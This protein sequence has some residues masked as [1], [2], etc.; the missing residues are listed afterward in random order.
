LSRL[1]ISGTKIFRQCFEDHAALLAATEAACAAPLDALAARCADALQNGGKLL[2]FGN[3][4]SA[5]DAQHLAA[6]LSIRFVADRR[7]LAAIALTTD[8]SALTACANDY[9]FDH[10]FSRQ[11]EALG[12]AGD[13]AIGFSTSGNSPNVVRAIET[14][15]AMQM[16]AA[17]FTGKSGGKLGDLAEPILRI[18]SKTTARI[19]EMH[20]LLGHILCAEIESRLGLAQDAEP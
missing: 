16:T 8:T 14:A 15:R 19:Q 5:A 18:P 17:A 6:E 4:G 3:G 11:I 1:T 2:L 13:V 20:S 9:G 7:A 12:R 10:V